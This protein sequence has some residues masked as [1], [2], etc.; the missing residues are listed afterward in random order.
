M[1][2]LFEADEHVDVAFVKLQKDVE[3]SLL[4]LLQLLEFFGE[5]FELLF[6]YG[7]GHAVECGAVVYDGADAD[8]SLNLTQ[9]SPPGRI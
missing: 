1:N 8:V 9:A 6:G 4:I 5:E 7:C 2:Q 3:C